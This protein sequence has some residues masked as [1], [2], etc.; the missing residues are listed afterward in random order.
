MSRLKHHDGSH[1]FSD[2]YGGRQQDK[3]AGDS[4]QV[5]DKAPDPVPA[6]PR[7]VPDNNQGGKSDPRR[8]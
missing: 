6:D 5:P 3:Q 4:T 7:D 1:D 8:N 2:Y